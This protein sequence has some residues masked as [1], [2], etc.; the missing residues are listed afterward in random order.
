MSN[1]IGSLYGQPNYDG[2]AYDWEIPDNLVLASPGGVSSVHHHWTKGF[3]GIGNTSSDIYAGQA[4]RYNAG[5]YGNLYQTGQTSSQF[6]GYYPKAPDYQF[7]QNQSPQQFSY[8][9]GDS[10][11]SRP[12]ENK[13]TNNDIGYETN[14][15]SFRTYDEKKSLIGNKIEGFNSEDE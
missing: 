7:W 4:Q 10:E 8:T 9:H 13:Y 2:V 14:P 15:E 11:L 1:Y 6:M 5:V 3:N 12:F